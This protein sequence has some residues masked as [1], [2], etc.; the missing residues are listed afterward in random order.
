MEFRRFN[1]I[2]L[3]VMFFVAFVVLSSIPF[4]FIKYYTL[5]KIA[6]E[7]RSSLNDSYSLLTD[8]IVDILEQVYIQTWLSNSMQLRNAL[9][10]TIIPDEA[11]RNALLN[12]I[13]QQEPDMLTLSLLLPNTDQ[14]LHF[15]KQKRLQEL[16]QTDSKGVPAF[17][18]LPDAK[19]IFSGET[20]FIQ[21][22]IVFQV[23]HAVFLPIDLLINWDEGRA[24][25]LHCVY[26][27]PWKL[28][29]QQ[30]EHELPVGNKEMYIV[31]QAGEILFASRQEHFAAGQ[32]LPP[33]L[34]KKISDS[35]ADATRIAQ[36]GATRK[37][38]LESFTSQ[39]I[40]YVW[41]FSTMSYV[42]WAVAVMEPYQL[43]YGLV[44]D[45]QRQIVFW[46]GVAVLLCI[47]CATFFAWFFS[48]FIVRAEQALMEAKEAADS[49]NR[50]KSEFLANMSHEIRTPLNAVIGFSQLLG[51][52]VRDPKQQSY[53]SAIQAGGRS[54]LTL[55]NDI[56]DL[57]KIEAGRIE[58]Q[59]EPV[60][61]QLIIEEVRQIFTMK[62]NEKRLELLVEYDQ[63]IPQALLLDEARLRQVLLNLVGNA[64]KFTD[65][66]HVMMTARL[67]EHQDITSTVNLL[68]TVEDTGIGIPENQIAAIF[69][70]FKQQDGQSTR[71]YG[72]TGLGLTIS[73]RLVE[74]MH[75]QINVRSTVGQGSIFEIWLRNVPVAVGEEVKT[76]QALRSPAQVY[77]FE[78]GLVLV[79]DDA[80]SNRELLRE[81]LTQADLEILEAEDGR[82][83]VQL[84][85]E[86]HPD[87]ILMD[88]RMPNLDGYE[89]TQQIKAQTETQAVPIIA[90]TAIATTDEATKARQSGF[91]GYLIK[92]LEIQTLLAELARFL[93][94]A[95]QGTSVPK[96]IAQKEVAL[97]FLPERTKRISE[98]HG[99]LQTELFP[100]WERLHGALDMDDIE[101]FAERLI[102]VS[103]AY[104]A[105]G[106]RRYAEQLREWAQ[107]F[108]ILRLEVALREFPDFLAAL[109]RRPEEDHEE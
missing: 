3:F 29:L 104:Q 6:D 67:V 88:L 23:S 101:A 39:G 33:S 56:L 26:E 98:L 37:A 53:L 64:V 7:M 14:P 93:P 75:G 34:K 105:Q 24:A 49:A 10:Y 16:M 35:L 90:L 86:H 82:Q 89:A 74:L 52:Q 22:P 100:V 42:N 54:L 80:P 109:N 83:A 78:R 65:T 91:D 45:T 51:A 85:Q 20:P 40:S 30:I 21:T 46:A 11:A 55:I 18:N 9:D 69:E 50:A 28:L 4:V 13:F 60:N 76:V 92:P 43:A 41:N 99:V 106:L 48:L 107:Q 97:T 79:A 17:F 96:L 94:A 36:A 5:R 108:D 71:K 95:D 68:L 66:G 44:L 73:R 2:W 31:N 103:A 8:R 47:A 57:S 15:L 72:G 38:Q 77:K 62:V 58:I 63:N 1:K 32:T 81:W 61:L 87:V 84:A 27:L 19:A 12:T 25:Q 70:A 59:P 102:A